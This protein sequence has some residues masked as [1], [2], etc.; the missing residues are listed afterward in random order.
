MPSTMSHRPDASREPE[1][2]LSPEDAAKALVLAQER[3][4]AAKR[5]YTHLHAEAQSMETPNEEHES[6]IIAARN[7][8]VA[9]AGALRRIEE[10]D[11]D[12]MRRELA[13]VPVAADERP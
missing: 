3:Y 11:L 2:E 10:G 12:A 4:N 8:T 6:A 9:L 13:A 1:P 7:L 5:Q